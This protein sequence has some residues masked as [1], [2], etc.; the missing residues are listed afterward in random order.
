MEVHA[1][2]LVSLGA[3]EELRATA[4]ME[5]DNDDEEEEELLSFDSSPVSQLRNILL[6]REEITNLLSDLDTGKKT[7]TKGRDGR[8]VS[9]LVQALRGLHLGD[10]ASSSH[11]G[12]RPHK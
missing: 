6:L 2:Y 7:L 10:K 4:N 9:D 8:N 12:S 11:D 3:H 5:V 1:E